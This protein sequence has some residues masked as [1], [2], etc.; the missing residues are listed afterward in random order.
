MKKQKNSKFEKQTKQ[1][2]TRTKCPKLN[3][4][5][6]KSK[7]PPTNFCIILIHDIILERKKKKIFSPK[8]IKCI[9]KEEILQGDWAARTQEENQKT[10]PLKK[11][12]H[13]IWKSKNKKFQPLLL[14][15]KLF[16]TLNFEEEEEKNITPNI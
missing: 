3:E 13:S 1:P 12:C 8:K 15:K 7:T 6:I 11:K 2:T 10:Q 4:K 14:F 9:I 5:K 16:H